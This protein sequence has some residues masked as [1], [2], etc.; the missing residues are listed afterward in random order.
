MTI[1]LIPVVYRISNIL[2]CDYLKTP[3]EEFEGLMEN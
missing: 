1:L 3:V 2:S